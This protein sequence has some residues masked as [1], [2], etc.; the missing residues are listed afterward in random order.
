[1]YFIE[2]FGAMIKY[3]NNT[4]IDIYDIFLSCKK[5]LAEM[6]SKLTLDGLL[7]KHQRIVINFYGLKSMSNK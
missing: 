1:M 7:C 4:L 5:F 6:F 2:S 3:F